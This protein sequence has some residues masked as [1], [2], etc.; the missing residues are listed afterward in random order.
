LMA[1]VMTQKPLKHLAV[2]DKVQAYTVDVYDTEVL[3]HR[4]SLRVSKFKVKGPY[5]TKEEALKVAL[6]GLKDARS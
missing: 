1:L 6:R 5:D 4:H 2:W 3:K